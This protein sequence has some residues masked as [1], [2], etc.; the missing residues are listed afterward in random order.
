ME[1]WM[2]HMHQLHKQQAGFTYRIGYALAHDGKE[3]LDFRSMRTD[4][5]LIREDIDKADKMKDAW[6]KMK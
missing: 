4:F 1:R 5:D 3:S 6:E 2:E